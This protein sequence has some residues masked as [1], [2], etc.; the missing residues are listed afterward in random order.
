MTYNLS[1]DHSDASDPAIVALDEALGRAGNTVSDLRQ[2]LGHASDDLIARF[3]DGQPV[4]V[5]QGLKPP[6]VIEARLAALAV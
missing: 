1:I 5:L 6:R 4:D 2:A 3:K